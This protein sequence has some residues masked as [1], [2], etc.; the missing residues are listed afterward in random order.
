MSRTDSKKTTYVGLAIRE[1]D[2]WYSLKKHGQLTVS[3]ISRITKQSR[4]TAYK[5]LTSLQEKG[6][7]K[8]IGTTG[9]SLYEVVLSRQLTKRKHIAQRLDYAWSKKQQNL[10][11]KKGEPSIQVFKGKEIKHVWS[12]VLDELPKQS[13]FYRYDAYKPGTNVPGYMPPGFYETIES[14][15]LER[16]VITNHGLRHAPY[17][18][19]LE[20]LSRMLPLS[21]DAFE[22]G[23]TEFI[24]NDKIA[25]IDL[26]TETAFVIQNKALADYA[27]RRFQFLFQ[28][29]PE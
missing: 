5:Y 28:Q 24:F 23:V 15:R 18:K 12:M 6:L 2:I 3:S 11:A 16:F 7:V 21:F 26:S 25:L 9:R 8:K 10:D 17:K 22:Q 19:R 4:P 1:A 20:G 14:K 27:R 13:I 29:L